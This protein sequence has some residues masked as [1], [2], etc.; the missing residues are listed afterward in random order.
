MEILLIII[1]ISLLA[2]FVD[3]VIAMVVIFVVGG[4]AFAIFNDI[5]ADDDLE[6]FRKDSMHAHAKAI[7]GLPPRNPK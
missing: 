5:P 1:I 7:M 6:A 2:M 3:P 4:G